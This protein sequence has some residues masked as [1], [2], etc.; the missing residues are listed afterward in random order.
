MIRRQ[1]LGYNTSWSLAAQALPMLTGV[2]ALP[3]LVRSLGT[4]RFGLLTTAWL[5]LAYFSSVD[6]GIGRAAMHFGA[7]ALGRGAGHELPTLLGTSMILLAGIGSLAGFV[8]WAVVPS[9]VERVLRIPN[10]LRA[11]AHGMLMVIGGMVPALLM[12]GSARLIPWVG[13]ANAP[14]AVEGS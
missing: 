12:S 10:P 6:L 11:E 9:L 3:F 1:N 14:N 13:H 4:E 8:W 5:I 2:L 7:Q